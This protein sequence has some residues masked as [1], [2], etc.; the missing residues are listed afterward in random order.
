MANCNKCKHYSFRKVITIHIDNNRI[1]HQ[2]CI[3]AVVCK[4]NH[5]VVKNMNYDCDY[6]EE[7]D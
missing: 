1:V 6:F 5:A 2:H 4:L 7:L 3:D